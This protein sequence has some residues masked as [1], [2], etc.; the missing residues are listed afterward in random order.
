[1]DV[2]V[3]AVSASGKERPSVTLFPTWLA[4]L[5]GLCVV[6]HS[7]S[8]GLQLCIPPLGLQMLELRLGGRFFRVPTHPKVLENVQ[9]HSPEPAQAWLLEESQDGRCGQPCVTEVAALTIGIICLS[10]ACADAWNARGRCEP[11]AQML[12]HVLLM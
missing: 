11:L 10:M 6:Q 1:M 3:L 4:A 12:L 2:S 8:R 9:S 5:R 7:F